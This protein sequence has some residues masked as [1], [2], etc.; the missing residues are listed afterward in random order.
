[1]AEQHSLALKIDASAAKRGSRE[2]VGAI[3]AVKAAVRDLERDSAGAFTKLKNISP[4]VDVSGLKAA[5]AEANRL[6]K[7]T[8]GTANASDRAAERIR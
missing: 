5:S 7:A 2:F 1:M 4:K 3:N 6:S 8:T